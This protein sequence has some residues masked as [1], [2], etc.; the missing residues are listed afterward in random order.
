MSFL[1]KLFIN[2]GYI[3]I[4]IFLVLSGLGIPIPEDLTLVSGGVISGL[5]EVN[6][7]TVMII[8]IAGVLV[9]DSLIYLLGRLYGVKVVRLR[10]VKRYLTLKRLKFVRKQISKYGS[11]FLFIS[12]FLPGVRASVYLIVAATKKISFMKFLLIDFLA[13]IISVPVWVYLGYKGAQNLPYL[14]HQIDKFKIWFFS[15]LG[16][17]AIGIIIF[18]IIKYKVKNK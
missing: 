13:T 2:Y 4:F 15:I 6:I 12:R 10:I 1:I 7:Y 16:L 11:Y 17:V 14:T 5:G 3:S 8:G 18:L 9:G